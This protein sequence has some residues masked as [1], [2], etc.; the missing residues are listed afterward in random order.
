MKRSLEPSGGLRIRGLTKRYGLMNALD[1][2]DLDVEAGEVLSVLGPSG[3]GKSTLL[4]MIAGID[5]PDGGQIAVD[6]QTITGPSLHLPPERR[7]INMVFQDYALWPHMRVRDIIGYGLVC[8]GMARDAQREQIGA[9]LDLLQISGMDSRYPRQLSGGQRQRVAIARALATDPSILLF[10]EPLSNLDVQL[11]MAMRHEFA[12]LFQRL[13][14][15]VV[16]VTH[17]PLEACAFADRLLVMREGRIEQLGTPAALFSS[18]QS[19]WVAAMAGFDSRIPARL[20]ARLDTDHHEAWIGSQ[21]IVALL[22]GTEADLPEGS[23][24]TIMLH[25]ASIDLASDHMT[26]VD[27][28]APA[29]SEGLNRLAGAVRNSIFEGR[30]WRIRIDGEG[31]LGL[32][33]V[34]TRPIENGKPVAVRFPIAETLAFPA[35]DRGDTGRGAEII[36]SLA[37]ER[38]LLQSTE[39]DPHPLKATA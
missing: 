26:P 23:P 24:V 4:A 5:R 30:Q 11:R 18:P 7:N 13:G 12:D 32:G 36:G 38:P 34:N 35:S 8:K 6:G 19:A 17:D 16:Y 21:R 2:L 29:A 31:G 33:L 15:T 9:L 25:P 37:P 10:D 20:G 28:A 22:R 27:E 39:A 3:C 1:N 14:K